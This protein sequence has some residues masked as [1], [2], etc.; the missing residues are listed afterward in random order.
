MKQAES[1]VS[2]DENPMGN[3]QD[4]RDALPGFLDEA[5]LDQ[6][7]AD[8]EV[9]G[10]EAFDGGEPAEYADPADEVEQ[11]FE[12]EQ[13]VTA[14]DPGF[15]YSP[16]P[17]GGSLGVVLGVAL[18]LAAAGLGYANSQGLAPASLQTFGLTPT[19]LLLLGAVALGAAM[20]RRHAGSASARLEAALAD[21]HERVQHLRENLDYLIEHHGKPQLEEPLAA[22]E[23]MQR[24]L[25][26]LQ[27]QDEKVTNL[28]KAIKM[29][30]KPLMEISNMGADNSANIGQLKTLLEGLAEQGRQGFARLET[31]SKTGDSH[32]PLFEELHK[33]FGKV[34]E[35]LQKQLSQLGDNLPR[36]DQLQQQLTRVEAMV[37]STGQRIDDSD[38]RKSLLRVE[39]W[40]KQLQ[41]QVDRIASGGSARDAAQQLAQKLE[42]AVSQLTGGLDDMK[43]G[44]LGVLETSV[45]DI[46]RE[47]AGVATTVATIQQQLKNARQVAGMGAS[48]APM[49]APAAPTVATTTT[50]SPAAAAAGG[51][52]AAKG[53]SQASGYQTGQHKAA[54]KN[55]LGAIAR[56][57]Q[58]KG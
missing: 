18:L 45:R 22:G 3:E 26:H 53:D 55:V 17:A 25:L 11:D 15:A 23:E 34:E 14:A 41:T 57:K 43:N 24:I 8:T 27:R 16:A 37:Q 47:M 30:G 28:T 5:P 58:M 44:N 12:P 20:A 31:A 50:T 33:Q 49:Q 39:E 1:A 56:L 9:D 54:A 2:E 48:A 46:Q 29:Y 19:T 6:P 13:D 36:G 10:F 35:R 21:Q 52:A 38:L 7:A 42:S 51:G 40:H 32:K 4:T